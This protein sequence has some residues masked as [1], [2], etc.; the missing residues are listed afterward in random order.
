MKTMT[1]RQLGGPC[2][3]AHRGDD[4]NEVIQ[5]QDQHLKDAVAGGDS[6]DAMAG[7]WAEPAGGQAWYAETIAAFDSLP[8][9]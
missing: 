3:E 1:C 6:S 8:D 2:D 7:R 5:A 9:D 4:A